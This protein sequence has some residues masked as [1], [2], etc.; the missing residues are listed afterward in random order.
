MTIAEKHD[1]N[2]M[3]FE[4]FYKLLPRS[5]QAG[6]RKYHAF[7]TDKEDKADNLRRNSFS[8]SS[9][10]GL[11]SGSV[12]LVHLD[13]IFTKE[14]VVDLNKSVSKYWVSAICTYEMF[15]VRLG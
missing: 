9:D 14:R 6:R 2:P 3:G 12:D 13:T 11:Y 1:I 7:V 10:I 15:R 8:L 4:K 5:V